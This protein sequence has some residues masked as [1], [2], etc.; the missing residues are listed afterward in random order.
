MELDNTTKKRIMAQQHGHDTTLRQGELFAS[1][2]GGMSIIGQMQ[3][4]G[5]YES[6]ESMTTNELYKWL[7]H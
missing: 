1:I 6:L 5:E 7:G 3:Y 2:H 4:R